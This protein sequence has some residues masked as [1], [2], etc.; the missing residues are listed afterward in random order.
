MSHRSDQGPNHKIR[1]GT[2]NS[3]NT[4]LYN[5]KVVFVTLIDNI[6]GRYF[7]FEKLFNQTNCVCL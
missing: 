2:I 1:K 6:N 5:I 3:V 7:L 4:L